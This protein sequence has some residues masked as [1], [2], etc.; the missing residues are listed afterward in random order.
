MLVLRKVRHKTVRESVKA[1]RR[2]VPRLPFMSLTA[3]AVDKI[4][5]KGGTI[6]SPVDAAMQGAR[7]SIGPNAPPLKYFFSTRYTVAYSL[8]HELCTPFLQCLG[9]LSLLPSV[10]R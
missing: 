5:D 9:Q 3:V 2:K 6:P 4:I 1:C 10:G 7:V 8:G